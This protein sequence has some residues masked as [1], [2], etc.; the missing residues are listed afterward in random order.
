MDYKTLFGIIAAV[1]GPIGYIPYF[2]NIF[3]GKTKPHVFSW[4]LWGLLLAIAFF[5]QISKGAGSG[6]WVTGVSSLAT[7]CIAGFSLTRG[8]KHITKS[9]TIS[10]IAALFGIVLWRT[11]K[12]PL[13]A[14][15]IV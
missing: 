2:I 6:A 7:F 12:N 1:L 9:D 4:G 14:V 10:F 5:A 3:K 13:A 15:F 11:T 8:E